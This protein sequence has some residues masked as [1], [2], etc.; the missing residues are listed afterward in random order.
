[1]VGFSWVVIA[2]SWA[3][4]ATC[5]IAFKLCRLPFSL[6]LFS[7]YEICKE[8]EKTEP[9]HVENEILFHSDQT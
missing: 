6:V 1:M 8:Y 2:T 5:T 9:I 3:L 7:F 4:S